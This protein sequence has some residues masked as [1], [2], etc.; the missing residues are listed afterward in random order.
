M[1]QGFSKSTIPHTHL[2]FLTQSVVLLDELNR[3]EPQDREA[4]HTTKPYWC[5]LF[6][7]GMLQLQDP[8]T[9]I[10]SSH[11][12][13]ACTQFFSL[14]APLKCLVYKSPDLPVPVLILNGS[15]MALDRQQH[16]HVSCHCVVKE[17]VGVLL[18]QLHGLLQKEVICKAMITVTVE[19]PVLAVREWHAR[20]QHHQRQHSETL[21]HIDLVENAPFRGFPRAVRVAESTCWPQ[22]TQVRSL[23]WE[24]SLEV[25]M[26]IHSSTFSWRIP[27]AEEP[28]S[29]QS[30][31]SRRVGWDWVSMRAHTCQCFGSCSLQKAQVDAGSLTNI[32]EV[33]LKKPVYNFL[34]ERNSEMSVILR[35]IIN[36][37]IMLTGF[38]HNCK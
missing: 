4:D 28:G 7:E 11:L 38:C 22:E 5:I 15:E 25:E 21:R 26:A 10:N 36:P 34:G 20:G 33:D 1:K 14:F 31:G 6:L 29:L 12:Y 35:G 16:L 3:W 17:G 30:M 24:D 8:V 9:L 32:I 27:W 37:Q 2:G 13:P 23:G 19:F 18:G